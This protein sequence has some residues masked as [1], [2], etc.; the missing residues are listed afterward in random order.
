MNDSKVTV[1]LHDEGREATLEILRSAGVTSP[2]YVTQALR[3]IGIR[4]IGTTEFI[5]PRHHIVRSKLSN[6]D[7]TTLDTNRVMQVLSLVS[8]PRHVTSASRNWAA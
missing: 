5:T 7:G 6:V 1:R 3:K 8:G 2:F 4:A